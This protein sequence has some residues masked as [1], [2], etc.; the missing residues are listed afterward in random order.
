LFADV[1]D[2]QSAWEQSGKFEGD[3]MLNEEQMRN[4]LIN[5]ASRWLNK[6]V[7]FVIDDVFSEY[8]SIYKV[9]CGAWS[10]ISIHYE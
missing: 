2:K 9:V 10:D 3:I 7:P 8:C 4:G 6:V 1:E 5:P